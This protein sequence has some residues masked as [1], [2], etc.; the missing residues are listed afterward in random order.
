MELAHWAPA[1][2]GIEPASGDEAFVGR[3]VERISAKSIWDWLDSK[4]W[5]IF[6]CVVY[7]Y[8]GVLGIELLR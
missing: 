8:C 6:A 4:T 2:F 3:V 1:A 7:G 5:M